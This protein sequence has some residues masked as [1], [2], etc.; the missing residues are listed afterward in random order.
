MSR[1]S[2]VLLSAAS[3]GIWQLVLPSCVAVESLSP[4]PVT[5]LALIHLDF[6]FPAPSHYS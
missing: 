4:E 2:C 6:Y 1:N 3:L 5:S